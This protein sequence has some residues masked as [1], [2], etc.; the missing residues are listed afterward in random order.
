[1]RKLNFLKAIIDFT[2]IMSMITVPVVIFFVGIL[3]YT[4]ESFGMPIHINGNKISVVETKDKIIVVL[5]LCSYLLLLYGL[6]LFKKVLFAFQRRKV[7]HEEN[8]LNFNKIG[9]IL[10]ISALISGIPMFLYKFY[11]KEFELEIG[12]NGYILMIALGLF[13]MILSELFQIAKKQKEE[14]EL[15]I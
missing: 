11:Q 5:L 14:N 15:T 7:F 1:M 3:F 9:I 10:I 13:F 6:F 12:L 4:N 8:C 2:W